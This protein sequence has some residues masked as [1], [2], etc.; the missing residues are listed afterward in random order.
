[1]RASLP[2]S[3]PTPGD[4]AR[5][6]VREKSH[7]LRRG[8]FA[9]ERCSTLKIANSRRKS[10]VCSRR[11]RWRVYRALIFL[12]PRFLEKHERGRRARAETATASA[13]LLAFLSNHLLLLFFLLLLPH[14]LP[15]ELSR[16]LLLP[17][18]LF[19]FFF[20]QALTD[21]RPR[22]GII[23]RVKPGQRSAHARRAAPRAARARVIN[24][25]EI[26]PVLD[27]EMPL[28]PVD[29]RAR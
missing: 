27:G 1:M 19:F 10:R 18:L 24:R 29:P 8:R 3:I 22:R 12:S 21:A 9:P 23:V 17:F 13:F 5:A 14:G 11:P 4:Y 28:L 6:R 26:K 2:I 15:N 16:F 7:L 20:Q 25:H